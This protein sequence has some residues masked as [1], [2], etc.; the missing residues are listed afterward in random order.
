MIT[1]K[2]LPI[3]ILPSSTRTLIRPFVPGSPSQVD[4][5]LF[6]IFSIPQQEWR[7]ILE[8]IYER[9]GLS[10][11]ILRPVFIRH[12]DN[13]RHCIP[14]NM[15]MTGE[16]KE[17]IGAYFTQ[18]YSLES[19]AL[20]NPSI[21]SHPVQDKKGVTKFIMSLRAI[22]EGHISSITFMEGE[23]DKAFN[24]A[25]KENS[26]VIY[27]PQREE[28]LYEKAL[29]IKKSNELGILSNLNKDIFE[30][31]HEYFSLGELEE[32]ISK[33]RNSNISAS[34]L[35]LENS[36]NNIR[37]L[38]LSNFTL[39]F[40][41][42]DISE[43]AIYPAS[44]SQSNGLEDARFV[45]FTDDDGRIMYYATFTAYDGRTVMPEMLETTDFKEFKVST[46]NGPA[47][48]NKGM[49]LFP[50]KVN[51]A[52][53]ML[54]RQDNESLYVM[55]SDNPYF[56][57]DY[58]P[59]VKPTYNWELIQ[60]GNCGSPV[61]IDEGWLVITHGVGPVRT[62][63]I[64]AM[65]LDKNKPWRV[66]GRLKNPLLEPTKEERAGY[67]PNVLYTCGAMAIG[68]TLVLPYAVGDVV[69]TF[70]LVSIDEIIE[71][72]KSRL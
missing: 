1:V 58:R 9:I 5:I 28:H 51:G 39:K 24:I 67:V 13:I 3:R 31:L 41:T 2:K 18:Q 15:E 52:Y 61:E 14:S 10:D 72:I 59:L 60:I 55:S 69:T 63:S 64:G 44:P 57:Y 6:R 34:N 71:N 53:M 50:R 23:V 21:I 36:L 66:I 17:F 56:W 43:R 54:G 16:Q 40:S 30:H 42:D 35:E 7:K 8:A 62:Y 26:P 45:R 19:T 33:K 22:G 65:L 4:H 38:A 37:M 70:A 25:L 49:A 32:T 68:R 46:L 20:F 29:F 11:S 27:E 12:F 48:K 47:A